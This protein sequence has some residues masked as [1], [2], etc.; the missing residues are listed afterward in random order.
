VQKFSNMDGDPGDKNNRNTKGQGE[1]ITPLQRDIFDAGNVFP[2]AW[3]RCF[4]QTDNG[5]NRFL[6]GCRSRFLFNFRM[7]LVIVYFAYEMLK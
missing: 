3:L 1:E 5:R 4:I 6:L 2:S 7:L